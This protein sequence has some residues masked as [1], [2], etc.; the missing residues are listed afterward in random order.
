MNVRKKFRISFIDISIP[1]IYIFAE[2]LIAGIPLTWGLSI[3]LILYLLGR[4]GI[5][6]AAFFRPLF[7]LFLFMLLHDLI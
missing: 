3:V 5:R 2:Y 1:L 6:K 4:Y 7:Y